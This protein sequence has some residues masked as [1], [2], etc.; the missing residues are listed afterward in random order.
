MICCAP[1][2]STS[3]RAL[4]GADAAA[5]AAGERAAIWRT[6]ARLSPMPIAASRSITCTFG[7]RCEALHPPEHVVVLDREPLALHE[8]H[9]GAVLGD[10]SRES[11]CDCMH[12]LDL[13]TFTM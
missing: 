8:L 5:D 11:A 7:N 12:G 10:R 1:A 9:D 13:R 3:A 2:S 4:D 6:S